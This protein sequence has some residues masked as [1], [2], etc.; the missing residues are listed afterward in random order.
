MHEPARVL[1]QKCIC[2]Y[3]IIDVHAEIVRT[4]TANI[5]HENTL[6]ANRERVETLDEFTK[7]AMHV[8]HG[9]QN[10]TYAIMLFDLN[11]DL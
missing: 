10:V 8:H 3:K 9:Q 5:Q 4:Q 1:A 11:I 7:H 6:P 2:D